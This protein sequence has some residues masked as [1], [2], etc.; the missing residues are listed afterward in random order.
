MKGEIVSVSDI[1]D[2]TNDNQSTL[3]LWTVNGFKI[4]SYESQE[5]FPKKISIQIQFHLFFFFK[6]EN[7]NIFFSLL[8]FFLGFY[9][10][11]LQMQWKELI[12]M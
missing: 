7:L 10:F 8:F 6:H 5:R 2:A 11:V 1:S 9:V 12:L 4:N 3:T